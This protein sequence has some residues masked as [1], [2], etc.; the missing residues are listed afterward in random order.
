[1][2]LQERLTEPGSQ[3]TPEDERLAYLEAAGGVRPGGRVYGLGSQAA[4]TYED[5]IR[6]P[7]IDPRAELRHENQELRQEVQTL[8][9]ENQEFRQRLGVLE[10]FMARMAASSISSMSP[11]PSGP[12][13]QVASTPSAH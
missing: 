13:A 1:M 7:R 11:T 6:M 12:S 4:I 3:P 8:R 9:N 5:E 2:V 10:E